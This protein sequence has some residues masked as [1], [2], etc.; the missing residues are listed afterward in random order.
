MVK[1]AAS[2]VTGAKEWATNYGD[3]ANGEEGAALTAPLRAR[4]AWESG[5]ADAFANMFIDNGSMLVGDTQ[6][7]SRDEI[8]GYVADALGGSYKGSRWTERP[9]EIRLLDAGTA[10]CVTDGGLVPAGSD[11]LDPLDASRATWIVVKRDGDWRI[12]SY[13]SSP[14]KG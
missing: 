7:T 4:A 5:D 9:R 13:Q 14:I 2:L 12:A 6:L 1:D 10:V 3:F 11:T 8:R